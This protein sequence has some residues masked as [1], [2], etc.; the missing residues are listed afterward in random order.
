[1][2]VLLMDL[3]KLSFLS[4]INEIAQYKFNN[5]GIIELNKIYEITNRSKLFHNQ[6]GTS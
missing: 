1:M 6:R 2:I 5:W 4:I 3:D